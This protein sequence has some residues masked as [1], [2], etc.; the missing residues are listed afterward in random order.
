MFAWGRRAERQIHPVL[1]QPVER[2]EAVAL[3]FA[4]SS[5]PRLKSNS[6]TLTAVLWTWLGRAPA[7]GTISRALAGNSVAPSN[8]EGSGSFPTQT[9]ERGGA[10]SGTRGGRAWHC[11]DQSARGLPQSKTL[12]GDMEPCGSRQRREGAL[13]GKKICRRNDRGRSLFV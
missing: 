5:I 1:N 12:R 3:P 9:A 7:T 2:L 11:P 6:L 13:A 8:F 4:F 10:F